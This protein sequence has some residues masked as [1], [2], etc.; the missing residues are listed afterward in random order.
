[1][2]SKKNNRTGLTAKQQLFAD[3]FLGRHDKKCHG[4]A[5]NSYKFAYDVMEDG[6]L[7]M[8]LNAIRVESCKLLDQALIS[9]YILEANQKEEKVVEEKSR[10]SN[11]VLL[12]K[13]RDLLLLEAETARSDSA[14]VTAIQAILRLKGVDGFGSERIE[15]T[16]TTNL[17]LEK[18]TK[19]LERVLSETLAD[20]NVVR[21]FNK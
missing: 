4:H 14:R 5:S 1:M 18:N 8:S 13:A 3:A 15:T 16:N 10:V 7:T 20:P 2:G 17:S 9:Q 12:E 19:E 21:L 11:A 6:K